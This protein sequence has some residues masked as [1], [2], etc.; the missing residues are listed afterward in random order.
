M[1]YILTQ[2]EYD[3]LVKANETAAIEAKSTLQKLCTMVADNMPLDEPNWEGKKLPWG[4]ILSYKGEHYCDRCPVE[5]LCPY[6]H[7][8]WSQ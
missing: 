6:P 2:E 4:C 5:E 1:Q 3:A 7:K 8:H